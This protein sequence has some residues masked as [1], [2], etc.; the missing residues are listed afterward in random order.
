LRERAFA[1]SPRTRR[2]WFDD[3]LFGKCALPSTVSTLACVSVCL[4][5][6]LTAAL[7]AKEILAY[8]FDPL[9]ART[10]GVREGFVH[11]LLMFLLALVIVV[12]VRVAAASW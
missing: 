5:V 9:T 7:L 11:Y 2:A 1:R 6:I 10:S 3:L 4:A 12:G 8:C